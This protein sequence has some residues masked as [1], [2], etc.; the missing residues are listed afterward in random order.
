M[1]IMYGFS[2]LPPDKKVQNWLT[3]CDIALSQIEKTKELIREIQMA[4]N[5]KA[6]S[7]KN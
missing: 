2:V 1:Q 7:S 4:E 5:N 3:S 6:T